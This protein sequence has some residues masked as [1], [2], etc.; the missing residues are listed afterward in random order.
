[1]V[2]GRMRKGYSGLLHLQDCSVLIPMQERKIKYGSIGKI[3]TV[4][5]QALLQTTSIVCAPIRKNL[6]SIYGLAHEV[7]VL[8][9][10]KFQPANVCII[11]IKTGSQIIWR[12]I[13]FRMSLETYESARIKG[14]RASHHQAPQ[15]PK[16]GIME[17]ILTPP[18]GGGG[19]LEILLKKM[20]LQ[21]MNLTGW[22]EK[23]FP[24]VSCFSGVWKES[25]GSDLQKF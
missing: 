14:C 20:E 17:T 11:P 12:M 10:L 7:M 8:T 4:T 15:P 25:P 19:L 23:K 1:M 6:L 13:F 2:T 16:G 3:F 21:E 18:L 22:K 5:L 24:P 9:V